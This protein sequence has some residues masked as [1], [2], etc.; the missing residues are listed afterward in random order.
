[1]SK[2]LKKQVLTADGCM[3]KTIGA[4][5]SLRQEFDCQYE[6]LQEYG[7][8]DDAVA[9]IWRSD[10]SPIVHSEMQLLHYLENTQEQG[11]T[12]RSRFFLGEQFI[13]T[14]KPPCRLCSYYFQDSGTPVEVRPSHRNVYLHWRIAD[15]YDQ[16]AVT[17]RD[18]LYR[19]LKQ[20]LEED[21]YQVLKDKSTEGSHHDSTNYF[22]AKSFV[23]RHWTNA[24][25]SIR[26]NTATPAMSE[27]SRPVSS[28]EMHGEGSF[29]SAR[30][31]GENEDVARKGPNAPVS[32]M[33]AHLEAQMGVTGRAA[34][35]RGET[36]LSALSSGA[37]AY[38]MVT[39][40]D[41]L[42]IG[43]AEEDEDED[44]DG[45][46]VL[47]FSGRNRGTALKRRGLNTSTP[48]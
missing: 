48:S 35:S 36:R 13:G 16:L 18:N 39:M 29:P 34:A 7:K 4:E 26:S 41:P 31:W 1:M 23:N 5:S 15:A 32:S 33:E 47:L 8:L 2:A 11:G 22:G 9:D 14:S 42:R 24:A 44:E 21:L 10:P 46:G 30:S 43:P 17:R 3:G 19:K 6:R 28:F 37:S 20:R 12:K 40:E 25:G 27:V 45:G 38:T